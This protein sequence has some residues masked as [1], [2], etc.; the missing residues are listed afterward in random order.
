MIESNLHTGRLIEEKD[1]IQVIDCSHCGFRHINPLPDT[2]ELEEFYRAAYYQSE[3]ADYFKDSDEDLN[4][5]IQE[6]N[7]CF[8]IVE[9]MLPAQSGRRVLDIGCGP[10]DLLL[11]GLH[12]GWNGLGVEPSPAA[13]EF[14]RGRGLNV[15]EGFFDDHLVGELG[16]FEFVHLSGVLEHVLD[17]ANVLRNAASLLAEDGILC[18]S[19]P[20]DYNP[21]QKAFCAETGKDH[22]WVVPQ[23]HLNYFD[24]D[25]LE[26][27][28]SRLGL[29]PACRS[30]NFPM[31]LFLL[32]GQDYV[33]NPSLGRALHGQRKL[34]ELTLFSHAAKIRRDFYHAMADVGLG[35]LAI[36]FSRR[37]KT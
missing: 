13:V 32:M 30:T 12:R 36:V 10:G 35:R 20:N 19:V 9:G 29:A 14:A 8:E 23:H 34:L 5:R 3:K 27:L 4:W 16:L 11:T 25:S 7:E 1:G 26:R 17:P 28:L 2:R 6:F 24:F 33:G 37:R 15:I 31:E 21:L 22:W 18:V